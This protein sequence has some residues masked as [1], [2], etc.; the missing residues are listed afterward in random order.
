MRK[1]LFICISLTILM[2]CTNT[3][4]DEPKQLEDLIEVAFIGYTYGLDVNEV[5]D[6][7][8]S[9]YTENL[10]CEMKILE[11]D[12]LYFVRSTNED[13]IVNLYSVEFDGENKVF[14]G[15]MQGEF[16]IMCNVSDIWSNALMEIEY[17]DGIWEYYPH[18]SLKDGTLSLEAYDKIK[19]ITKY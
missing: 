1:V 8:L 18:V 6:E 17:G 16:L 12:E 3:N 10:S 2:G 4:V 11:G 13:V 7:N 19:D 9:Q 5:I 14:K 15:A